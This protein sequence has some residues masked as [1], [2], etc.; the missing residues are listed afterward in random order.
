VLD[1]HPRT[2]T[3]EQRDALAALGRQVMRLME[4][5][6]AGRKERAL[7]AD[8]RASEAVNRELNEN[9]ERL[10]EER[11]AA[12][13]E[14]EERFRQFA[15]QSTEAFW[16]LGVSP[17]QVLYVSPAVSAIAGLP[18]EW[19]YGD[20]FT[21][22]EI[23]HPDDHHKVG[24]VWLAALG[25]DASRFEIEC[26]IV[27]PDGTIRWAA[28]SGTPIRDEAGT[29]VRIGGM[30][31]DITEARELQ[32]EL[33]QAQKIE[34]VGQLAGGIA[35][36]FNNI[37]TVINGTADIAGD[38]LKEDDPVLA[39]LREIGR[40]GDRAAALT[41][42][43]LAFSR[44]QVLQPT[45]FSLNTAVSGMAGMLRRLIG[46]DIVLKVEPADDLACVRADCGQTEQVILNLVV[47]ARVRARRSASTSPAWRSLRRSA[48]PR[49]AR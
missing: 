48:D 12:L 31:R 39:D 30:T 25:G 21:W 5:R 13:D 23:I 40:A 35:H 4:S 15:E 11:T 28:I 22:I 24:P 34:S 46:A 47:N 7:N 33:L 2:L 37:L 43:L 9:L 20:P 19:F 44:K 38:G 16:F 45:V 10:V 14:S 26:R 1:T 27:R 6:I 32:T 17:R 8:L 42:Q 18:Q 36:D 29:I 41:R 49:A 3:A